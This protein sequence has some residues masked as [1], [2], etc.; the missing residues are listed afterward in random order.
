MPRCK[1]LFRQ[2]APLTAL[3]TCALALT[4]IFSLPVVVGI[5]LGLLAGWFGAMLGDRWSD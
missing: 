4:V 2:F 1:R 5:A 3:L